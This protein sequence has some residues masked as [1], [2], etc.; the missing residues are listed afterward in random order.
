MRLLPPRSAAVAL[1]LV[2]MLLRALL[3]DGW[4]PSGQAASFT[5][6]SVNVLHHESGKPSQPEQEHRHA[7]CAFAAAAPLA[8][9]A[10]NS[11]A[12]RTSATSEA[13]TPAR[14]EGPARS[15]SPHRPNAARAP[16][17]SA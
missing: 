12:R 11:L 6:C 5:I 13:I 4:M 10:I 14:A 8:P 17:A 15:A 3:P 16:P 9:P 1:A 7:P 2:A